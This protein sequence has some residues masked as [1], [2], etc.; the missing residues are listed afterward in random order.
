MRLPLVAAALAAVWLGACKLPRPPMKSYDYPAL[1]FSVSFP[2]PPK[3]SNDPASADGSPASVTVE[4]GDGARDF[5]ISITNAPDPSE[6][7]DAATTASA[8][9]MA[10]G[11]GAEPGVRTYAATAEGVMGREFVLSK[12]GRA[13]AKVRLF[14]AGGRFYVLAG[15]SL[16]GVDDPAVDDFLSSF[17]VTATPPPSNTAANAPAP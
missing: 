10:K 6:D 16:A 8:A 11:L 1:G 3:L 7:I 5:A 17:H 9:A 15:K 12:N 14:L 2:A 4:S 13:A